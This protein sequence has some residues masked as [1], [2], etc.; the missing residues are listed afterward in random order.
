MAGMIAALDGCEKVPTPGKVSRPPDTVPVTV[1][2]DAWVST[3]SGVDAYFD[4]TWLRYAE[5][6]PGWSSEEV[7]W[8]RIWRDPTTTDEASAALEAKFPALGTFQQH[9]K[10][11]THSGRH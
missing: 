3:Y 1:P 8:T 9:H 11:G 2:Q 6:S 10:W 7:N 5:Q 4:Q